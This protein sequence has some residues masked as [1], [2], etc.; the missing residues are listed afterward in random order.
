VVQHYPNVVA[1]LYFDVDDSGA[2][3]YDWRL[4]SSSGAMGAFKDMALDPYFNQ[5]HATLAP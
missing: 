2:T 5:P 1:F 4:N 3:N